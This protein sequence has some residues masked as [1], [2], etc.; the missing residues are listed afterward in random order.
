MKYQNIYGDFCLKILRLETILDKCVVCHLYQFTS[1]LKVGV[2]G[3]A[4]S[5][6]RMKLREMRHVSS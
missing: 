6:T 5:F 2:T 4:Q 3:G 1:R